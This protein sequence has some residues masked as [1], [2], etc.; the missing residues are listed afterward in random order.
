MV[1][2]IASKGSL[3]SSGA[4]NILYLKFNMALICLATVGV[5]DAADVVAAAACKILS[6]N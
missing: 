3:K 2:H 1:G 6:W 5:A 4:G